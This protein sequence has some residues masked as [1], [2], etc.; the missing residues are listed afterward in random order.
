MKLI[1]R[2][3]LSFMLLLVWAASAAAQTQAPPPAPLSFEPLTKLE[4][5]DTQIGAVL[6]KNFTYIGSVSGYGGV[7]MVTAYEFVETRTGRKEYGIG[8]EVRE[9]GRTERDGREA[10]TYVDYDEI[11]ALLRALDY[12][13]KIERSSTMEN[14]EAQYRSRGELGV[15]TFL[16]PNGTLQ[17]EIAIGV[18]RRAAITVSLGKLADF[19]KL[20]ADAKVTIDKI[21]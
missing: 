8:I 7:A 18:F 20:I 17:S 14:F 19:R 4:T 13:S 12:I 16:R 5:L 9:T 6:L 1:N 3:A 15:A 21:K 10:R 2:L 11:E